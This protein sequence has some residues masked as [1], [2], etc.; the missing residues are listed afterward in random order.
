LNQNK[1]IF[2]KTNQKVTNKLVVV[3]TYYDYKEQLKINKN[4]Y[5]LVPFCGTIEC[6]VSI[7][8]DTMTTS[9]CVL[10]NKKI[11]EKCFRCQNPKSL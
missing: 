7:K 11:T 4:C 1:K 5:F 9:R 10:K 2:K 3:N 8:H 6:E